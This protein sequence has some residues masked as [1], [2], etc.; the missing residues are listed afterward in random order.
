MASA[1]AAVRDDGAVREAVG[2][3]RRR[4]LVVVERALPFLGATEVMRERLV[5]L[6]EA[7]GV[8]LLDGEPDGAV[9]LVRRSRSTLSYATSCV[10]A[11][12][13]M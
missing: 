5:E 1:C 11:C 8:Q 4:A 12:L 2:R 7:V 9:Q 10:S 13:N 3:L 6:G